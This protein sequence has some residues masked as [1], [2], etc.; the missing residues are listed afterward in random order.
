MPN[1][2]FTFNYQKVQEMTFKRYNFSFAMGNKNHSLGVG[3]EWGKDDTNIEMLWELRERLKEFKSCGKHIVLYIDEVEFFGDHIASVADKIVLDPEGSI[4][5][6]GIMMGRMYLKN[7]LDKLGIGVDEW[8]YFKYKSAAEVLSREKM[9]E[10]DR[11]QRQVIIEDIYNLIKY[12]VCE[13]R[14]FTQE[15]F[16]RLVNDN[17]WGER[18]KIAVIYGL[19]ECAMDTGIKARSL[20]KDIEW[21]ANRNDIKAVAFRVAS[22]FTITGSIGVIGVWLY[23]KE[24]KE[25]LGFS[26]DFVKAGEHA[27]LGFGFTYPFLGQLLIGI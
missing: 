17:Y 8:R 1:L 26:T 3:Y 12:D 13:S 19:G 14:G 11:E 6:Q 2:G 4:T 27:D 18:P 15:Q 5:L 21:A 23:N 10:A 16:E 24:L 22:P 25:R 7:A 20:V 9:S